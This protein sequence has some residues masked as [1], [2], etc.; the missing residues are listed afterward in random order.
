MA[1]KKKTKT[2][3]STDLEKWNCADNAWVVINFI[4]QRAK[5][6]DK[7]DIKEMLEDSL[8]AYKKI[9][10]PEL[11][12]QTIRPELIDEETAYKLKEYVF[13]QFLAE[14]KKAYPEQKKLLSLITDL[15]K[16]IKT[17]PTK[18]EIEDF[19]KREEE[20]VQ[21]IYFE[22]RLSGM[23]SHTFQIVSTPRDPYDTMQ[24]MLNNFLTYIAEIKMKKNNITDEQEITDNWDKF[25]E[26]VKKEFVKFFIKLV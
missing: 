8:T 16:Y 15:C 3:K 25:Y 12:A 23:A 11:L 22:K 17:N 6:K 14:L 7:I 24:R 4:E 20:M 5:N 2:V 26:K 1:D 13:N 19:E 21:D 9:P 18:E 10:E